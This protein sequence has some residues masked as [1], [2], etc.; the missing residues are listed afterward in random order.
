MPRESTYAPLVSGRNQWGGFQI[1]WDRRQPVSAL[2]RT[3]YARNKRP[4]QKQGWEPVEELRC[5][6]T[7]TDFEHWKEE[8]NVKHRKLGSK[9]VRTDLTVWEVAELMLADRKR[10]LFGKKLPAK[11]IEAYRTKHQSGHLS[12]LMAK[13]IWHTDIADVEECIAAMEEAFAPKPLNLKTRE[14]YLMRV[15]SIYTYAEAKDYYPKRNP[16]SRMKLG[17]VSRTVLH[18]VYEADDM[19]RLYESLDALPEEDYSL[20]A[21]VQLAYGMGGRQCEIHGLRDCDFEINGDD[22]SYVHVMGQLDPETLEWLP[23][24]KDPS[25]SPEPKTRPDIELTS[26]LFDVV[27]KL[28]W[29]ATRFYGRALRSTDLLIPD[30]TPAQT[31]HFMRRLR[32]QLGRPFFEEPGYDPLSLHELRHNFGSWLFAAGTPI[33]DIAD[34]MGDEV[35]TILKHYRHKVPKARN[36]PLPANPSPRQVMSWRIGEITRTD[37]EVIEIAPRL[38]ATG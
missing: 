38:V 7:Q 21:V 22:D 5:T 19:A 30:K 12:S 18:K 15:S 26:E 27:E 23:G 34:Q 31:G 25:N 29:R 28:R 32:K 4:D 36:A 24:T 2:F 3:P 35:E 16:I 6:W 20:G 9:A 37:A 17:S 33:G 8:F 1:T 11:T 10:G 13:P 14:N